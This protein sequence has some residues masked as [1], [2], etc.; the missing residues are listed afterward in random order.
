VRQLF[1]GSFVFASPKFSNSLVQKIA[2][3]WQ[4]SPIIRAN[5][6]LPINP[7]SGK[8]NALNGTIGTNS[9]TGIQRPNYLCN[10][11]SGFTKSLS[12]YYN[13]SCIVQNGIGQLGNA[14][15]N[16]LR[17]DGAVVVN[18]SLAR[19]FT[20]LEKQ[21]IEFR[22]EAYNLPN[23]ANFGAPGNNLSSS[24]FGKVT[25]TLVSGGATSG[26][27]GDPRILQVALKYAF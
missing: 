9:T 20:I 12:Q 4:L 8:D 15:R 17:A 14:G 22:A 2:G 27:T 13:N 10:P 25:S 7:L 3:N 11:D 16:S 5:S 24:T 19:K 23:I 6:G 1:S 26:Q 18:V 21:S